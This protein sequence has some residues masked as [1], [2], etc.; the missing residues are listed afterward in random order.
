MNAF[1]YD[2]ESTLFHGT[3]FFLIL[4]KRHN[5]IIAV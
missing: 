4:R 2:G 5:G 3:M 1:L